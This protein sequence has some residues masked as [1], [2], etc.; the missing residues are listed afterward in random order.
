MVSKTH[1]IGLLKAPFIEDFQSW[2]VL[3]AKLPPILFGKTP[4]LMP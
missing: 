1:D 4:L 3:Y 2:C